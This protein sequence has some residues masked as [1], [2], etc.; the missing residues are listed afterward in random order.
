MPTS[1]DTGST[2]LL[3]RVWG[4]GTGVNLVVWAGAVPVLFGTPVLP[5]PFFFVA[6]AP[7]FFT[8]RNPQPTRRTHTSR[9]R[10]TRYLWGTAL[11]GKTA[12]YRQ[13]DA[14]LDSRLH[15]LKL[16]AY[17]LDLDDGNIQFRLGVLLGDSLATPEIV[18]TNLLT[19]IH[20]MDSSVP[21]IMTVA[22]SDRSALDI[23]EEAERQ[24][25]EGEAAPGTPLQ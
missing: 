24:D 18:R 16:G 11:L 1:W 12:A 2:Y 13:I 21:E 15:L 4:Y 14:L 7:P 22:F 6:S 25:I 23:I 3:G 17:H 8:T 5:H 19:A 20:M 10:N 9:M